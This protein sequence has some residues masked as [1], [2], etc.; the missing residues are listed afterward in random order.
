M[1]N[2]I[3]IKP[4]PETQSPFQFYLGKARM[5]L[6]YSW[7]RIAYDDSPLQLELGLPKLAPSLDPVTKAVA[8][9]TLICRSMGNIHG[10][11]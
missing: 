7:L 8:R 5:N 6:K 3:D 10:K 1:D 11:D 2:Y 9:I 4:E